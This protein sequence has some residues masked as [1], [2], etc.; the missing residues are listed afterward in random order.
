MCG[1]LRVTVV[2][3][4]AAAPTSWRGGGRRGR[5]SAGRRCR[6]SPDRRYRSNC[7]A[8]AQR[9][10]SSRAGSRLLCSRG[11]KPRRHNLAVRLGRD[12]LPHLRFWRSPSRGS[13]CYPVLIVTLADP[14]CRDQGKVSAGSTPAFPRAWQQSSQGRPSRP[15]DHVCLP[16]THL[17]HGAA[18]WPGCRRVRPD[19]F[20]RDL[21]GVP[22]QLTRG[23]PRSCSGD[24]RSADSR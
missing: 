19:E 8:P 6:I 10:V 2:A 22:S 24:F 5:A 4:L 23:I 17:W 15:P 1:L 11:R 3:A 7:S 21:V 16:I 13:A 9:L 14:G 20:P 18:L 12:S